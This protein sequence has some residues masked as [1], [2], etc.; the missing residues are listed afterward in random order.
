MERKVKK[1]RNIWR[2]EILLAFGIIVL[3]G[4]GGVISKGRTLSSSNLIAISNQLSILGIIAVAQGMVILT[5]NFDVSVGALMGFGLMVIALIYRA[6][7]NLFL[8]CIVSFLLC[9]MW[10]VFNGYIVTHS[11]ISSF[12]LTLATMFLLRG[13]T[14]TVCGG[15]AI[16]GVE[17]GKIVSSFLRV[18]EAAFPPVMWMGVVIFFI[19][20]TRN[21]IYG[22]YIYATGGNKEAAFLAGVKTKSVIQMV[23]TFS[24]LLCGLAGF[25][26]FYRSGA[27]QP[28]A[29]M[30]TEML[31]S[32]AACLIG[33]ISLYGGIGSVVG[34][35]LGVFL[36]GIMN[37][38]LIMV[39]VSPYIQ[40]AIK[41]VIV[42]GVVLFN[43]LTQKRAAVG[44]I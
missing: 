5:G 36:I 30:G 23:Y 44:S 6:I 34:L 39:G 15:A 3:L 9:T 29:A 1:E 2:Y 20:F 17:I 16:M 26:Y 27:A 33:G 43:L 10:G 28:K 19:W 40:I 37:N 13:V 41:G 42:L 22:Q 38:L 18:P 21:T 12:V 4:I 24:G 35:T 31:D 32:I 11:S 14:Y 7:G 8:A 25:L